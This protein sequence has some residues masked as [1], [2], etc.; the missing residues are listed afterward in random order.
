MTDQRWMR[1]AIA[2]SRQAEGR[3]GEN[4]PV[5]CAIISAKGQLLSLGHTG[6]GGRPHAETQAMA[7][8]TPRQLSGA[9]VYVTLEPCAHTGQTGPCAKALVVAGVARVVL[10]V[11]DP[12]ARVNG[13]GMAILRDAGIAVDLGVCADEV[14]GVLAGFLTRSRLQRPFVTWKTATSLDGMI[15]LADGKKRW[16][17]GPDMR[18]Y[19]HLLRSRVDGLLSAVGTVLADDPEFTCRNP[20]L[21]ADSPHRFIL[22]SDLRVPMSSAL[23]RTASLVGVTLFCKSDTNADKRQELIDAGVEVKTLPVGAGRK[24]DLGACL[25]QI[26]DAGYNHILVEAGAGLSRSLLAQDL[27]D[28]IVWTQ[29][30]HLIG[31]DGIPAIAGLSQLALPAQTHYMQSDEGVIGD[32]R[33]ITMERRPR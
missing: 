10:G 33:W 12:D 20:G 9:T 23:V 27:I 2:A 28:R 18:R 19:V 22:D 17:T 30:Q 7:K 29:S 3:S 25:R 26:A 6:A 15:A 8:L 13:A 24:L 1:A 16:L 4:P 32:D 5:G 11:Q 21:S 31:G 14:V